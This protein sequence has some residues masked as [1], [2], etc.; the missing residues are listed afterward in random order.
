MISFRDMSFATRAVIPCLKP[1]W[2]AHW[3]KLQVHEFCS[4]I[5]GNRRGWLHCFLPLRWW[6]YLHVIMVTL[7]DRDEERGWQGNDCQ[8]WD[9]P[10]RLHCRRLQIAC[11]HASKGKVANQ[12]CRLCF[13]LS[14]NRTH[15]FP[16]VPFPHV[17]RSLRFFDSNLALLWHRGRY[18][19]RGSGRR[20]W[21]PGHP[22]NFVLPISSW[23]IWVQTRLTPS[24]LFHPWQGLQ[25]VTCLVDKCLWQAFPLHQC[26]GV[27]M[28]PHG[29]AWSCLSCP[30]SSAH[31][32]L[33]H[34]H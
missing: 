4:L 34:Y 5:R 32:R 28:Q 24:S 33:Q 27:P 13:P 22:P 23:H 21:A 15:L 8:S 18:S 2:L 26:I 20:V 6:W 25:W 11:I 14:Q 9:H 30:W 7:V 17:T 19:S 12:L 29:G 10:E 31:V 1:L 3:A 16:S